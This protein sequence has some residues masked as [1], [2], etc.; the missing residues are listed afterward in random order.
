MDDKSNRD[1]QEEEI[2]EENKINDSV[3]PEHAG[4][5]RAYLPGAIQS[6]KIIRPGLSKSE[7][8]IRQII[9]AQDVNNALKSLSFGTTTSKNVNMKDLIVPIL[10]NDANKEA[11]ESTTLLEIKNFM[12]SCFKINK[13]NPAL[14]QEISLQ[15]SCCQLNKEKPGV[16]GELQSVHPD[17]GNKSNERQELPN[18]SCNVQTEC[19]PVLTITNEVIVTNIEPKELKEK[20][21]T[22][23]NL[24]DLAEVALAQRDSLSSIGSNVCRICMTRGRERQV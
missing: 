2:P 7:H 8:N 19:L 13:E 24:S 11:N 9:T 14:S 12:A 20:K 4:P 5:S 16:L 21:K 3:S 17:T 6:P 10:N 15:A 18:A 1:W 23:E 22:A